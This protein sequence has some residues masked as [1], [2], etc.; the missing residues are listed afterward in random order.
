MPLSSCWFFYILQVFGF[1]E[2][3]CFCKNG[4][5]LQLSGGTGMQGRWLPFILNPHCNLQPTGC[6]G[7]MHNNTTTMQQQCMEHSFHP[8]SVSW[9]A[10]TW[11][12]PPHV[13]F[14]KYFWPHCGLQV[15]L[16]QLVPCLLHPALCNA[17]TCVP[18]ANQRCSH[19]T[20]HCLLTLIF[21]IFITHPLPCRL[22]VVSGWHPGSAIM[23][24][25]LIVIYFLATLP[26]HAARLFWLLHLPASSQVDCFCSHFCTIVSRWVDV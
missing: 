22:I 13:F 7:H 3:D 20:Q 24:M 2:V 16:F 25:P 12:Q 10:M 11:T 5:Q 9:C 15:D 8:V 21:F 1:V 6:F 19:F 18:D 4:T 17:P 26:W 23:P 14:L